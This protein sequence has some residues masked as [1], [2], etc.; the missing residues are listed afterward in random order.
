M[1][2]FE[3]FQGQNVESGGILRH[4]LIC[5]KFQIGKCENRIIIESVCHEVGTILLLFCDFFFVKMQFVFG[6]MT[7]MKAF[8]WFVNF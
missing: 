2:E 8:F 4:H 7:P 1:L 6:A 3:K 5:C